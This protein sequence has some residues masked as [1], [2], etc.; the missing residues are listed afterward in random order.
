MNF[1]YDFIEGRRGTW[2]VNVKLDGKVIGS[3]RI[4]QGG[5]TYFPRNSRQHGEVFK[6]VAEVQRSLES[7]KEGQ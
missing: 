2:R 7:D 1:E 4:V 6:S 5:F 3:I